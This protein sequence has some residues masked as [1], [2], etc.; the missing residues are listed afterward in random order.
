MSKESTARPVRPQGFPQT[1]ASAAV[2]SIE[3]LLVN[4]AVLCEAASANPPKDARARDLA[5]APL[6]PAETAARLARG[7]AGARPHAENDG[8]E[9]RE[10]GNP[11]VLVVEDDPKLLELMTATFRRAGF[12]VYGAENGRLAVRMLEKLSPDLMVTDIVMPEME[13]IATM[14]AARQKRPG[15]SVIAI[16]GGGSYGRGE[17][18]L[19]W[20]GQLGADQVLPKPFRMAALLAAARDV[21][22]ARDDGA[23]ASRTRGAGR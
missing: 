12:L 15:I 18:Y 2:R 6:S 5:R 9:L 1:G 19:A 3:D 16:S 21:L 11:T 8:P 7:G 10:N 20:A 4:V 13:G 17:T 22:A 14:M 23:P